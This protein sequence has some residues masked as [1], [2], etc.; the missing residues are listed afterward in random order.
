V[1][2]VNCFLIL[3]IRFCICQALLLIYKDVRVSLIVCFS[4]SCSFAFR[5]R[6]NRSC[7]FWKPGGSSSPRLSSPYNLSSSSI[8]SA[9]LHWLSPLFHLMQRSLVS[10]VLLPH[11]TGELE[12]KDVQ[13]Y[14]YGSFESH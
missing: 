7:L 4:S 9:G 3:H 14:R 12:R 2:E 10:P 1:D 11:I 5:I 8:C 13:G 6:C